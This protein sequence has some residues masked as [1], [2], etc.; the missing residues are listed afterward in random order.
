MR[1]YNSQASGITR[2][3]APCGFTFT[4]NSLGSYTI[5]FGFNVSDRFILANSDSQVTVAQF[6]L[7]FNANAVYVAVRYLST[8]NQGDT[9]DS[10]F[11]IFVF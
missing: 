1:C 10:P 4:Y 6:Q 5:N 8:L 11:F 3:L 9:T 7:A 2:S